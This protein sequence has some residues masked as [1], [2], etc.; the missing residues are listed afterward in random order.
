MKHQMK[1][2]AAYFKKAAE[3][4]MT[5]GEYLVR[6]IDLGPSLAT[7]ANYILELE[8]DEDPDYSL[9]INL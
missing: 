8:Y 2:R 5:I 6:N 1:N 3:Q 4:G 9:L 7:F